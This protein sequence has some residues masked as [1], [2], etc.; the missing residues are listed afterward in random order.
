[1]SYPSAFL[2]TL[3]VSF[4]KL[5]LIAALKLQNVATVSAACATTKSSIG[6]A[7]M[8]GQFDCTSAFKLSS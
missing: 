6:Q 4:A 3:L 7:V 2:M 5:F 8:L 1:M